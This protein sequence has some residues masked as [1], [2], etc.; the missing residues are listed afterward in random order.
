MNDRLI[1]YVSISSIIVI[2]VV[3]VVICTIS[4]K[5]Y[6]LQIE[7]DIY[8]DAKIHRAF[9]NTAVRQKSP[10]QVVEFIN[11]IELVKMN[12]IVPVVE[13]ADYVFDLSKSN[14]IVDKVQIACDVNGKNMYLRIIYD[15][16]NK[17]KNIV[18]YKIKNYNDFTKSVN[19]FCTMCQG[20]GSPDTP[21]LGGK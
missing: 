1:K 15:Y 9:N 14:G 8:V 17:D 7:S 4:N 3:I 5:G 11:S 13:T 10:K 16:K 19:D 21:P 20:D 6:S 18:Q 2:C 12:R